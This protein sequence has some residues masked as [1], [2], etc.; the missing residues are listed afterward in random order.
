MEGRKELAALP[1]MVCTD[2]KDS[3]ALDAVFCEKE[4][5]MFVSLGRK[6]EQRLNGYYVRHPKEWKEL[7][8]RVQK[9]ES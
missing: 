5:H 2:A 9:E 4:E 6:L 3:K 8:E 7:A 1:S